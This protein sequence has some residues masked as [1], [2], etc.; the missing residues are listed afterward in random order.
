MNTCLRWL[1][2]SFT[3]L[4]IAC[5]HVKQNIEQIPREYFTAQL[6]LFLVINVKLTPTLVMGHHRPTNRTCRDIKMH[7]RKHKPS[8]WQRIEGKAELRNHIGR[9][10]QKYN[11]ESASNPR[12][13]RD[14]K[15]SSSAE[16]RHNQRCVLL[17]CFAVGDHQLNCGCLKWLRQC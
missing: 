16:Q 14:N 11:V 7:R 6:I 10:L 8:K 1:W 13:E 12:V 5:F 2:E 17:V 4:S 3:V 15:E 9:P